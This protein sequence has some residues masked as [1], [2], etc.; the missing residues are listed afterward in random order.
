MTYPSLLHLILATNEN[1]YITYQNVYVICR[2]CAV[3]LYRI[4]F[5]TNQNL[6]EINYKSTGNTGLYMSQFCN[7]IM[8]FGEQDQKKTKV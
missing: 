4:T 8:T 5:I 7:D 2:L 1:V 6:K 3:T